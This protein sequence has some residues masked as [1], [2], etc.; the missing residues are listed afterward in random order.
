MDTIYALATAP[1]RAGV[2]VF[3]LSGPA[4][5][6]IAATMIAARTGQ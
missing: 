5:F 2:S 3:R 1:G 6:D 4:A